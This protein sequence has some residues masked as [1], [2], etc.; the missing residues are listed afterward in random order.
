MHFSGKHG[1]RTFMFKNS[2]GK[3]YPYYAIAV[4]NSEKEFEANI[5]KQLNATFGK[6]LKAPGQAEKLWNPSP[7]LNYP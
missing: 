2:D 4:G 1:Q 7:N 6:L 5:E 3:L